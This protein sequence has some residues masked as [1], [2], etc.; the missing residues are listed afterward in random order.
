MQYCKEKGMVKMKLETEGG[1]IAV[2]CLIE[3]LESYMEFVDIMEKT[4]VRSDLPKDLRR[5]SRLLITLRKGEWKPI[6]DKLKKDIKNEAL[7]RNDQ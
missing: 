4:L 3:C 7:G 6:L 1:K 2:E 5:Y